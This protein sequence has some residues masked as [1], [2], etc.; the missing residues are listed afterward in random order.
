MNI[1]EQIISYECGE[2]ND[3]EII[4]FFSELIR[5]KRAWGFQGHYGRTANALIENNIID[6]KGNV[7]YQIINEL[8]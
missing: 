7:N 8:T 4:E 1:T 5:T 6:Q 3:I 2:L